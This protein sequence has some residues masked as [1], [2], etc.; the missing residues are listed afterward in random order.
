MELVLR[1]EQFVNDKYTVDYG[2]NRTAEF[3][4][5]DE[6]YSGMS[7]LGRINRILALV[8]QKDTAGNCIG[9]TYCRTV[10]VIGDGIVGVRSDYAELR[11]KPMTRDNMDKC[12]VILYE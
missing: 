8:F 10:I 4:I 12:V 7:R 6:E 11:G 9:G 2:N 1:E 5:I 3:T